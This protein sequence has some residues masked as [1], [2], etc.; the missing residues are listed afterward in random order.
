MFWLGDEDAGEALLAG[1]QRRIADLE[2]VQVFEVEGERAERPG[3]LDFLL[4]PPQY[5]ERSSSPGSSI[6]TSDY[7]GPFVTN[8][9]IREALYPYPSDLNIVTKVSAR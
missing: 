5:F 3:D 4:Q 9:I 1:W 6:D 7:Y 2:A 8:E